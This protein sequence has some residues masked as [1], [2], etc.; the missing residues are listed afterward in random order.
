M[1]E[2]RNQTLSLLKSGSPRETIVEPDKT[3]ALKEIGRADAGF[4]K[5]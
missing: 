5:G 1:N 2:L 4:L 3:R